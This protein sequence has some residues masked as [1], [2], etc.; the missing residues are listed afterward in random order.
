METLIEKID[1]LINKYK[2]GLI[3]D[4]DTIENIVSQIDTHIDKKIDD[5]EDKKVKLIEK[6]KKMTAQI[7][8]EIDNIN[9]YINSLN[10][11][12]GLYEH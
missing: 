6:R 11:V 10:G 12:L 4:I 9:D 2:D 3:N 8:I 7:N 1:S 5:M